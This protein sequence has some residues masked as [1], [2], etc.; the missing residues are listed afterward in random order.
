MDDT[1]LD[2]ACKVRVASNGT[3]ARRRRCKEAALK[4]E[5]S[6]DDS[7]TA[8]IQDRRKKNLTLREAQESQIITPML[9]WCW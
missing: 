4:K 6:K 7:A 5:S 1:D 9:G 2:A 8:Q 3:D